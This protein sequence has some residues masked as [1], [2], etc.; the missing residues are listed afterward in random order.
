M[1]TRKQPEVSLPDSL[2]QQLRS[3]SE[4]LSLI[5]ATLKQGQ[6]LASMPAEPANIK[7]M[8]ESMSAHL[9]AMS[10]QLTSALD[11]VETNLNRLEREATRLKKPPSIGQE[12]DRRQSHPFG[13]QTGPTA[14]QPIRRGP[15]WQ[16]DAP[17]VHPAPPLQRIDIYSLDSVGHGVETLAAIRKDTRGRKTSLSSTSAIVKNTSSVSVP[18]QTPSTPSTTT[19]IPLDP[20]STPSPQ[21]F[22]LSQAP[23]TVDQ[24][25]RKQSLTQTQP[26]F[27][28]PQPVSVFSGGMAKLP[29]LPPDTPP[30]IPRKQS[31][32]V[33][34]QGRYIDIGN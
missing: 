3:Q 21:P 15:T 1:D 32:T 13:P 31:G 28:L 11:G 8:L 9:D 6:R 16:L 25:V 22:G 5:A 29:P 7:S 26:V 2:M 27:P 19:T 34:R 18:P 33:A 17:K 10:V 20:Q 24:P 14:R 12:P 4:Q 23:P 30:E